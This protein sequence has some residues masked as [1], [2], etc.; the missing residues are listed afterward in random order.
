MEMFLEL[1]GDYE[2]MLLF[3]PFIG[4]GGPSLEIKS[5]RLYIEYK[6]LPVGT[7]LCYPNGAAV[8]AID[9]GH[10]VRKLFEI[11]FRFCR[12]LCLIHQTG[13]CPRRLE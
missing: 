6:S 4:N 2:S 8:K 5:I 9:N 13:N 10:P 11:L 7:T 12:F 3:D 1:I